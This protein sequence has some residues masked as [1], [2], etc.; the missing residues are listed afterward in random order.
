[1]IRP[2][3]DIFPKIH[4]TVFVEDS[5]QVIGDVEI[6]E[7]SSLWFNVVARGDVNF[8]KIGSRTNIQDNSVLHVT[9][10]TYPLYIGDDVTVGHSVT[11]HGC[12]IKDRCLIAMGVVVL[13]GAEVGEDSIVGAGSVVT[14]G[15]ILPPRT[16]SLGIPARPKRELTK[17]EIEGILIS[18][19]NYIG[20]AEDY[21]ELAQKR[22]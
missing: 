22:T 16:L 1:M 9:H 21:I 13:D 11:L 12:R 17:K 8:I 15:M 6:G 20:Y 14:E 19:R 5:A 3:K 7:Y 2:Y 10:D 18:S 4:P